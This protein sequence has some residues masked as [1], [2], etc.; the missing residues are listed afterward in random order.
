MNL[1]TVIL[2]F[3]LW[4]IGQQPE[5]NTCPTAIDV[6]ALPFYDEWCVENPIDTAD[7]ISI[8]NPYGFLDVD[9]GCWSTIALPRWYKITSGEFGGEVTMN[10]T[11]DLCAFHWL[12][13]PTQDDTLNC[14][15]MVCYYTVFDGCPLEGGKILS[16]PSNAIGTTAFECWDEFGGD[17]DFIVS[18]C[19]H[20][21]CC[22]WGNGV[23]CYPDPTPLSPYNSTQTSEGEA[24]WNFP[25]TNYS[26]TFNL[27][28]FKD[29]WFVIHPSSGTCTASEITGVDTY[30]FGCMTV[31]FDG[32]NLLGA[33]TYPP[34]PAP[35]EDAPSVVGVYK[36]AGIFFY[37]YSDLTVKK[38]IQWQ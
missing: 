21:G 10:V 9:W 8:C 28:P 23:Y 13:D 36:W 7:R 16:Y 3:P 22:N 24:P 15:D 32:V 2:L 34:M 31:S 37:V 30:T 6:D 1:G 35:I 19:W 38:V 12:D 26:V 33:E 4:C 17:P 14:G 5:V 11:S 25:T 20:D 29:Y 18:S 27:Q